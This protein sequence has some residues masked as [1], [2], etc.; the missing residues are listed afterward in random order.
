MRGIAALLLAGAAG[1]LA[2]APAIA[3]ADAKTVCISASD[4]GQSLLH[5]RHLREART[6]FLTCADAACPGL[7]RGDCSN[8]LAEVN[9]SMPTVVVSMRDKKG[10][11]ESAVRVLVDGAPFV[12][13]LDG[14]AQEIDPGVHELKLV[15]ASGEVLEQEVI[16]HEGE[17]NR[18][19]AFSLAP[20]SSPTALEQ[21]GPPREHT[22][23]PWIV[24]AV[25][26]AAVIAG[27]AL[28]VVGQGKVNDAN[29]LCPNSQC[30]D[31]ATQQEAANQNDTGG[32]LKTA[33]EVTLGVGAAALVGGLLWHFLEPGGGVAAALRPMPGP[34]AL[35]AGL[36][37]S[38]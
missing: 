1:A 7:V 8:W 33:G 18:L 37:A 5:D 9:T 19:L 13:H 10:A 16:V 35:G 34:T 29:S 32:H 23:Y 17:K 6:A 20:P 11:E 15:L 26:G 3:Q 14:V 24:V 30:K 12:D 22:V 28:F 36:G 27:V 31:M 25:G 4:R 21:N 38:F 2:S